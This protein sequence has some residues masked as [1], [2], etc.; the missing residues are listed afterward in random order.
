MLIPSLA[1]AS[2]HLR[3]VHSST[4]NQSTLRHPTDDGAENGPLKYPYVAAAAKATSVHL[5]NPPPPSQ[6]IPLFPHSQVV[7]SHCRIPV[8]PIPLCHF[9][10]FPHCHT[11]IFHIP[12]LPHPILPHPSLPHHPPLPNT[13]PYSHI[14]HIPT[15]SHC[16]IPTL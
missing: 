9:S 8:C 10:T 11:A 5:R 12:T 6:H 3:T 16:Y 1:I 15:L 14:P 4:V 2:C 7:T 13:F